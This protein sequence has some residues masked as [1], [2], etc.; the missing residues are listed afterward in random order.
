MPFSKYWKGC[1][2]PVR[3]P[4]PPPKPMRPLRP[5]KRGEH[6]PTSLVERSENRARPPALLALYVKVD[7]AAFTSRCGSNPDE[8]RRLRKAIQKLTNIYSRLLVSV[9]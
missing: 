7:D 2:A 4:H 5:P 1:S 9:S 3:V 6:K 8:L